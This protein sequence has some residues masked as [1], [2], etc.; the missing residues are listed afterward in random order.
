LW[1]HLFERVR[2]VSRAPIAWSE[3]A[4]ILQ[5]LARDALMSREGYASELRARGVW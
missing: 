4:R 1:R 2:G 3:K 5:F